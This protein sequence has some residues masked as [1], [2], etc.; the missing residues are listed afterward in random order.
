MQTIKNIFDKLMKRVY[1]YRLFCFIPPYSV[2]TFL[3]L[4]TGLTL[5]SAGFVT[6]FSLSS[7]T[8]LAIHSQCS[9]GLD[10]DRNGKTDYPQD[11][12]CQSLDDDYEGISTS[13][14]FITIT[15]GHDTVAPG[16]AVVYVLTL[17]QQRETSRNV[18]ITLDL[19]HQSNVT[20]ASDGGDFKGDRVTW[21]NVSIYQNVTRTLTVNVNISPNAKEGQ[22]LVARV[23]VEGAEATDTTLVKASEIQQGDVFNV[24]VTDSKDYVLPGSTLEYTVRVKNQSTATRTTDVRLALPYDTYF[25]SNSEGG[26]QDSYNV[27]WK[28]VSFAPN[29]TKTFTATVQIDSRTKDRIILRAKAY[30]GSMIALDQTVARIGL[31]YNSITTSISDNRNTAEVGQILNYTVKVTNTS[32]MVATDVPVDASFPIYGEFVGATEGGYW[33]GTNVRWLVL[34]I[35][36]KDTRTLVYSVRVRADAPLGS[37]LTAAA[38]ADNSMS[39]DTTR[40]VLQST[41]NGLVENNVLFRKTADRGEAVPGGK[42]RYTLFIR[43]TLDH[44]ISDASIIDRFDNRYLSLESVD[45]PTSLVSKTDSQMTW[46]VP[47]LKPGESWKTSYVLSVAPN[48]PT[49]MQLDNVATLRG[50]DVNGLSLTERVRTNSSGVL[51]EFP[52]TGA[53]MDAFMA[54]AVAVLAMGAGFMQKKFVI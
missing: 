45:D 24:S 51:R 52:M 14:N 29:E 6:T 50:A 3:S 26:K 27:S 34:Q 8:T 46:A 7:E 30:A 22:Y 13:G 38:T 48:A 31:P 35:A 18:N 43:N 32:D 9:D 39:R 1:K 17:K 23:L 28:A 41:E 21:T 44:V 19:P 11:D 5:L 47:V 40:V 36:P 54:A 12:A 25:I 20:G 4:V 37:V 53:G 10:N 16:G 49:G 2:R 42:I 15:D 33:D